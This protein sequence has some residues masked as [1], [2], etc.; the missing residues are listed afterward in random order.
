MYKIL[1]QM[2][3][4]LRKFS[5][6]LKR[7]NEKVSFYPPPTFEERGQHFNVPY[8]SIHCQIRHYKEVYT[9]KFK[10]RL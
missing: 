7:T 10:G 5:Q 6:E 4:Q 1:R 9:L 2:F 8:A 3:F